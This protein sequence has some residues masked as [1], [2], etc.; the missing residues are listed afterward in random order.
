MGTHWLVMENQGTAPFVTRIAAA[1]RNLPVRRLTT[2]QLMSQ[3]RHNT[4]IDLEAADRHSRT[5]GP[6]ATMRIPTSWPLRQ[7][8]TACTRPD[9]V[10]RH[11][12]WWRVHLPARPAFGGTPRHDA[13]IT[14]DRYGNTAS[15]THTVA[16]VEEL[17][18]GHIRPGEPAGS[19]VLLVAAGAGITAGAAVYRS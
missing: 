12:R 11:W 16:L 9:R 15:T 14:V 18:A 10:A 13:V 2:A 19:R 5:P 3:T 4:H 6:P 8:P 7:Q 17:E 1:G